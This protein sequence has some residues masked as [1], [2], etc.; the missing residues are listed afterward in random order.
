MVVNVKGVTFSGSAGGSA[1]VSGEGDGRPPEADW[2]HQRHTE[3]AAVSHA[4]G[5]G[6]VQPGAG[7]AAGKRS[8]RYNKS[9]PLIWQYPL[10]S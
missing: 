10:S 9:S 1:G 4:E 5:E 2:N 8:A 6:R 3:P 7:R